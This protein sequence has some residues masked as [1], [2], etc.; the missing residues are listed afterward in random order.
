MKGCY[1]NNIS[2]SSTKV[3][4]RDREEMVVEGRRVMRKRRNMKL[5]LIRKGDGPLP[6]FMF[7]ARPYK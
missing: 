7:V 5:T 2:L 1:Y 6:V 3:D 4:S